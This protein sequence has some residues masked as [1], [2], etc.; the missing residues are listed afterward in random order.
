MKEDVV[1]VHRGKMCTH[2]IVHHLIVNAL[3]TMPVISRRAVSDSIF[4][5]LSTTPVISG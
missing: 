3:S 1:D 2:A 4:T 5:A